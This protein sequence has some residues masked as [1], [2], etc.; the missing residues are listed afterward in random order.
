M[1]PQQYGT[2]RERS[3]YYYKWTTKKKKKPRTFSSI[4]NVFVV[5]GLIASAMSWVPLSAVVP[6]RGEEEET[7]TK[8]AEGWK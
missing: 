8:Q 1:Y 3:K 4:T 7:S 2:V 6:S 5:L